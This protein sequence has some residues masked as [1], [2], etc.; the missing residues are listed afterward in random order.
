MSDVAAL[1]KS[2]RDL[3]SRGAAKS[4]H[5]DHDKRNQILDELQ[6]A[7]G[8]DGR[9]VME[10]DILKRADKLLAAK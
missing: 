2:F 6:S 8:L 7:V 4:D 10:S 3:E 1:V 9:M 5:P